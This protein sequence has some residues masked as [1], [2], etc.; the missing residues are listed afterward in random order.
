MKH[1]VTYVIRM[2]VDTLTVHLGAYV[3]IC[4]QPNELASPRLKAEANAATY[5]PF[6]VSVR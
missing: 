5:R 6:V 2:L 1:Q 3:H 4:N